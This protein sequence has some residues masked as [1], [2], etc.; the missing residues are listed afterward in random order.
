MKCFSLK[1][2]KS[3]VFEPWVF[4]GKTGSNANDCIVGISAS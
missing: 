1:N 2:A 4:A 3:L